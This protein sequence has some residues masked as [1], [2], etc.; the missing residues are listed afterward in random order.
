MAISIILCVFFLFFRFYK[1][2]YLGGKLPCND[3]F[4]IFKRL[5]V[6]CTII[7]VVCI[8]CVINSL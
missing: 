3:I 8:E 6:T 7:H 1:L 4:Q 5:N 2:A